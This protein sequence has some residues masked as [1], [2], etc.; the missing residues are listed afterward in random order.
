MSIFL[1]ND[2]VLNDLIKK[3]QKL[4]DDDKKLIIDKLKKI[5]ANNTEKFT[6]NFTVNFT[7][8]LRNIQKFNKILRNIE[9]LPNKNNV[10]E[11]SQFKQN[12]YL[13]EVAEI[14][15][16]IKDNEEIFPD[17][18]SILLY[19]AKRR[20]I[21]EILKQNPKYMLFG[22]FRKDPKDK[23][24]R[25]YSEIQK[26]RGNH[27]INELQN[28]KNRITN[29][30]EKK[31]IDNHAFTYN[32]I[33]LTSRN[34]VVDHT[35]SHLRQLAI[36]IHTKS[37]NIIK[38]LDIID[39][40]YIKFKEEKSKEQL[41]ELYWLYMQTC[42]FLRGSASIGEIIFSALLQKYFNCDFKL[43]KEK[44][45]PKI[46]PDIHALSYD[47]EKFKSLFWQRFATCKLD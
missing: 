36:W 29:I 7:E 28:Q 42:P 1:S 4:T 16:Y 45:I 5:Y 15:N 27:L 14:I 3:T 17:F 34:H 6:E 19:V 9:E 33:K 10:R 8:I 21:I 31:E 26:S 24:S 46:I 11:L 47:L 20:K 41:S 18:T 38:L 40:L 35:D 12:I 30:R 22:T 43:Y 25:F 39:N 32:G 2:F 23:D 37:E 44:I 13:S